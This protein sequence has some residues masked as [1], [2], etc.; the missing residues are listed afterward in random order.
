MP[1]YLPGAN[2]T[3]T[4]TTTQGMEPCRERIM[5]KMKE[6]GPIGDGTSRPANL[7]I[8]CR[9]L[10]NLRPPHHT[11][12]W[13]GC[14][15]MGRV[16]MGGIENSSETAHNPWRLTRAAYDQRR[17]FG[18]PL[19]NGIGDNAMAERAPTGSA[20]GAIEVG[21]VQTC[22]NSHSSAAIAGRN[23][24]RLICMDRGPAHIADINT[25]VD[26]E[27]PR[28]SAFKSTGGVVGHESQI[29]RAA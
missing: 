18:P 23:G 28:K 26:I 4:V 7:R 16:R 25:T 15:N 1:V 24:Q 19:E 22:R 21:L 3:P 10:A 27:T 8:S 13:K 11:Q 14:G 20:T 12:R 29:R 9:R 5:S 17:L 6:M 2:L